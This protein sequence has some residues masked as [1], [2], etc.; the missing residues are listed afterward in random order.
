[1][2]S[3]KCLKCGF[4]LLAGSP[5]CKS[6]GAALPASDAVDP[7]MSDRP[8]RRA[9]NQTNAYQLGSSDRDDKQ[10][11]DS[12]SRL[13]FYTLG[14]G[15]FLLLGVRN[16]GVF[17]WAVAVGLFLTGVVTSV[18][19]IVV[20]KRR[21]ARLWPPVTA[22]FV[23]TALLIFAV[24]IPAIALSPLFLGKSPSWRKYESTEG[25]FTIQ[26]PDEPEVRIDH[27]N[28]KAGLVPMHSIYADLN[29]GGSCMSAYFDYSD[30]RL[31]IPIEEF[32]DETIKRFVKSDNAVLV[33]KKEIS[34]NGYKGIE[35]ESIPNS[36]FGELI[37]RSITRIYWAPDTKFLY[38][39]HVTGPTSGALFI[40]RSKFLDSF[41]F[42][43]QK[44][45]EDSAK[46]AIW[47]SPL[48]DAVSKGDMARVN[49][50][51]QGATD[52]DKQLAMT[53]A[54]HNDDVDAVTALIDATTSLNGGDN[55]G[56]TPLML[57]ATRGYRCVPLLIRAGADLNAQDVTNG[58]T[59][60]VWSL[61]EGA[62]VSAK[63]LISAGTNLN[64]RDRN[65]KTALMHAAG[66][67][68]R[69]LYKEV[70]QQLL[71][72]GADRNIQ[73]HNGQTALAIA[74]QTAQSNPTSQDQAEMVRLLK[75]AFGK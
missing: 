26:M 67:G 25:K 38:V 55:R 69:P 52:F 13:P 16:I 72:S 66:L 56:R 12:A 44:E 14:L 33:T 57:A 10:Q 58:W 37:T 45:A 27:V 32:L 70:V 53:I 49:S 8:E 2:K 5:S 15:I 50:A 73:D 1:M 35:I 7:T 24:V 74:E 60:L 19:A 39:N 47:N 68:Y 48:L 18:V 31:T 51:L 64:L 63:G 61:E 29:G 20:H 30:Y 9:Q 11:K 42:A 59:A 34:L 22:L 17:A 75:N 23:N 21:R 6:C 62:A 46:Q 4:V 3:I 43:S 40:Q 71:T 54:V 28:S 65:G 36:V 41:Q